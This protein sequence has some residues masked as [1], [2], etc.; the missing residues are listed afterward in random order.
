MHKKLLA[1]R[2]QFF[3]VFVIND[4]FMQSFYFGCTRINIRSIAIT[5]YH[6]G[7]GT[8]TPG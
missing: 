1:E 7:L 5:A 2:P 8:I 4:N 3:I 6:P